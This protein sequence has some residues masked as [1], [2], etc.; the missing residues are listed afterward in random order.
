MLDTTK[1][2]TG[3][4]NKRNK[5]EYDATIKVTTITKF[6]IFIGLMG[7]II[8]QFVDDAFLKN[9]YILNASIKILNVISSALF[10]AGLV[11]IIVEISTIKNLVSD[12]FNKI[13]TCNFPL[14]NFNENSLIQLNKEVASKLTGMTEKKLGNTIYHYESNLLNSV[15]EKYYDYHNMTYH[16]T[17]DENNNCF[18]IKTKIECKLVNPSLSNN[19]FDLG[20]KL[21]KPKADLSLE[22]CLNLL[23]ISKFE[24]NKKKIQ[25]EQIESELIEIQE[26]THESESR[27]YDYKIKFKIDLGNIVENKIHLEFTYSIPI[28]DICQ[29]F[30][31]AF[32]CKN[33]DH[34]IYINQDISTKENWKI[35]ANAYSTFYHKQDDES[36]NFKVEQNIDTSVAIRFKDWA[37]SGNGYCVFYQKDI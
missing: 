9:H 16:I 15:N 32:P 5:D 17:P 36:S 19:V 10:S 29:S 22:E 25:I 2:K 4:A 34:K 6:M 7:L 12:A 21:Y 18:N 28:F 31:L 33:M 20:M 24:I 13:L 3:M 37:F 8:P 27:Y 23:N 1:E 26:I 35:S 14:D 11:S 30:K